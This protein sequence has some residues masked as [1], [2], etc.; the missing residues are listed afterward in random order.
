MRI[1]VFGAT[2]DTGRL[3][4]DR[5]LARGHPVV[6]YARNPG[7][8]DRRDERLAVVAGELDDQDAIQRAVAGSDAV[9]SLLGPNGRSPGQPVARGT[10]NVVRAVERQGV[11][12]LV[13]VATPSAADPEDRFDV[14]FAPMVLLVRTLLPSAYRDIVATAAAVRSS[15]LDRTLVRVPLL[16]S[17]PPTGR[18][19]LG[20]LGRSEVGT[21]LSRADLAAFLLAAATDA[22]HV[23]RAPVVSN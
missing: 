7:K 1:A 19:R 23:R 8:L 22:R 16:N 13:A 12:R 2:G 21:S 4:V 5:A 14:R 15:T 18:V 3:L 17:K 6:A 11:R 9:V 10:V 20:Y